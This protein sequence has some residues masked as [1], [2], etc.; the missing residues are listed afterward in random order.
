MSCRHIL[1][2]SLHGL[3]IAECYGIP[4]SWFATYGQGE[5][6]E[7]KLDDDQE[8]VDHRV[9]DFYLGAGVTRLNAFCLERRAKP[10]WDKALDWIKATWRPL[11]YSPQALFEA[12]PLPKAVEYEATP[13][14]VE[15]KVL[16][17]LKF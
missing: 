8:K 3:V 2:T 6:R 5:G 15:P 4:S 10:E 17:A 11:A 12:F 13:W 7:L 16:K 14:P 1:S 9:R